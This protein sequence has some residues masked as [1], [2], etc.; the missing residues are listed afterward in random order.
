[1]FLLFNL[2]IVIFVLIIAD[3]KIYK[4]KQELVYQISSY[5]KQIEETVEAIVSK[6]EIENLNNSSQYSNK[7]NLIEEKEFEVN[8]SISQSEI[9]N[10]VNYFD[11]QPK[12]QISN[13]YNSPIED[14]NKIE[15]TVF[16]IQ[17]SIIKDKKIKG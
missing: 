13:Q 6:L 15:A 7:N 1:M 16:N 14:E 4:K 3:I 5:Q 10:S 9:E 8:N 12:K 11:N 2:L 17:S